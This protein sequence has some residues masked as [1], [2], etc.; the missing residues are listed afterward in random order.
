[1]RFCKQGSSFLLMSAV[2]DTT[3]EEGLSQTAWFWSIPLV[4]SRTIFVE[5][6]HI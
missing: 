6:S 4:V 1:M 5:L 2:S 3:K